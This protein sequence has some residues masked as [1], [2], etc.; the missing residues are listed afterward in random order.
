MG[1]ERTR[2]KTEKAILTFTVA[3]CGE[4]HNLGQCHENI[5]TLEEAVILYRQ[6]PPERVNG[7]P[8]IGINLHAE[9]TD[10]REDLQ[11][12][13]L[14]GG[15]IDTGVIRLIPEFCGNPQVQEIIKEIIRFFP[16]KEIVKY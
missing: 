16:D 10:K 7:I 3:E 11:A 1:K 15:E 4:Y 14:S 5:E 8:S 2:Q 13:I 9:G 6:I 12:D